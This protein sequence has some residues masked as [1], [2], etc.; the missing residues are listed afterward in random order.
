MK[1]I[2]NFIKKKYSYIAFIIVLI[3]TAIIFI[4]NKN[5]NSLPTFFIVDNNKIVNEDLNGDGYKDALYIK[6]DDNNYLVQ[7]NLS[8]KISYSLNPNKDILTL[9][10]HKTYWPMK[11][12]LEDV[13]RDNVKEIFIQSSINEKSIQHI[14]R[15]NGEGYENIYSSY[16]NILGFLDSKNNKTP[17]IVTGNFKNNET[18]L[19]NH[20]FIN[21]KFKT[22]EYAYPDNYI[23]SKLICDFISFIENF[24]NINTNIP[25]YFSTYISGNELSMVYQLSSKNTTY[26]FQDGFFKEIS[27]DSQDRPL[28]VKWTLNFKGIEKN[29]YKVIN[30]YTIDLM[31][32]KKAFEREYMITSINVRK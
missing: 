25:N 17:K 16:Y 26:H 9:G 8:N 13:S 20:I 3:I 4:L 15:F 24:P 2:K 21:N 7:I 11:V 18:K 31:L 5:E 12:I 29:D 32:A 22:F 28:E 1:S 6:T 10:E 27:Y 30:N 19:E 23:G 14:F